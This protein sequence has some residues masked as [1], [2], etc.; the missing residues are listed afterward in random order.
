M[1]FF[2][3]HL[4][5]TKIEQLID[6]GIQFLCILIDRIKLTKYLLVAHLFPK[7]FQWGKYQ[8]ERSS[9]FM[10]N[11]GKEAELQLIQFLFLLGCLLFFQSNQFL[12]IF[13]VHIPHS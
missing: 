13:S 1:K 9:K 10:T 8:S 4:H 2:H 7:H 5:L 12:I 3:F 6:K 11:V